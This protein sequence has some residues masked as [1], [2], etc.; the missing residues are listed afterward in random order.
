MQGVAAIP[1]Q[2]GEPVFTAP[3]ESR[4]FGMVVALCNQG[5]Y[6]WDDFKER[7]IAEIKVADCKQEQISEAEF[8]YYEYW[9]T[10]F[11]KLLISKGILTKAE[12]Q[13]RKAEFRAG[14]RQEVF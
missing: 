8:H 7:L 14:E 9:S 5:K 3:W 2:N 13:A 11:E 1:R 4:A 10:A 12:I 6:P